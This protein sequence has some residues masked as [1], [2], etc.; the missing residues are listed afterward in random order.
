VVLESRPQNASPSFTAAYPGAPRAA[1]A[2][3]RGYAAWSLGRLGTD[4]A[5][6][7]LAQAEGTERDAGVRAEIEAALG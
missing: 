6:E 5:R 1:D 7:L 4:R 3:L 2:R